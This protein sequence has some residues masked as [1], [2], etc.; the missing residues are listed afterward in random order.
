MRVCTSEIVSGPQFK[1]AD[2]VNRR[3]IHASLSEV[4]ERKNASS[5]TPKRPPPLERTNAES[6]YYLKQMGAHTPMVV[7]LD[8]GEA[9][10]GV[11]EWYDKRCIKLRRLGEPNLLIMKNA[12]R[13]MYKE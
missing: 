5:G 1:E 8:S 4:Q 10:H 13:L 9:L 3:L 12:I 6:F 11:I 7:V 2:G